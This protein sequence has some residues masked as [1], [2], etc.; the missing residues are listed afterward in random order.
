VQNP[1]RV[2]ARCL[3]VAVQVEFTEE[4]EKGNCRQ[5]FVENPV[6]HFIGSRVVKPGIFKLRVATGCNGI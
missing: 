2:A 6:F 5:N 4:L 3:H 1:T